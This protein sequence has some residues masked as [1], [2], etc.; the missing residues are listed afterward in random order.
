M[1]TTSPAFST[2]L[3]TMQLLLG[4]CCPHGTSLPGGPQVRRVGRYHAL[5][6]ELSNQCLDVPLAL[7]LVPGVLIL[8]PQ[9]LALPGLRE[10]LGELELPDPGLQFGHPLTEVRVVFHDVLHRA[11]SRLRDDFGRLCG[12]LAPV[13]DRVEHCREEGRAT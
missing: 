5:G 11:S 4:Q 3:V 9:V 6:A 1:A 12:E 8:G 2:Y 10:V 13:H 7:L